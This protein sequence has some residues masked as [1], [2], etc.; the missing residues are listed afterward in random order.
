MKTLSL[1]LD[2]KVVGD[3]VPGLGCDFKKGIDLEVILPG[4]SGA[5][6]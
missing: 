2:V 6:E 1:V 3:Q 4:A 5:L